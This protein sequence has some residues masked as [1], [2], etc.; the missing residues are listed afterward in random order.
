MAKSVQ[1]RAEA[2][3]GLSRSGPSESQLGARKPVPGC[4][5]SS[6][7]TIAGAL[8]PQC[9]RTPQLFG[10]GRVT[11]VHASVFPPVE[12]VGKQQQLLLGLPTRNDR[13][14]TVPG[15]L[16]TASAT[17]QVPLCKAGDLAPREPWGKVGVP[18][19]TPVPGATL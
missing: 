15:Q 7:D 16:L 19:R 1:S 14:R 4:I 2:T 5:S 8:K 13:M 18:G 11:S 9:L 3:T 6:G 10:T 12:W 17:M